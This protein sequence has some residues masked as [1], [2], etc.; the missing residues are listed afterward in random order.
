M[1]QVYFRFFKFWQLVD[2]TIITFTNIYNDKIKRKYIN[3]LSY[4]NNLYYL[5]SESDSVEKSLTKIKEELQ[6][7]NSLLKKLK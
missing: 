5:K 4:M 1:F 7:T 6:K 2:S 3:D